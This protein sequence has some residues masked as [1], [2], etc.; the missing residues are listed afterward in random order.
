M[1][2]K[3]TEIDEAVLNTAE[4]AEPVEETAEP[5]KVSVWDEKE[6]VVIPLGSSSDEENFIIVSVN[7]KRFQIQRGIPV[8][9][10]KPVAEVIRNANS[11]HYQARIYENS[12]ADKAN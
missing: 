6:T 8:K 4:K 2:A 12:K 10:P 7:G 11:M 9:V 5:V 3:K 1:P